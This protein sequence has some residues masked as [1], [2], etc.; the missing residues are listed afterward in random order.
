MTLSLTLK[1]SSCVFLFLLVSFPPP[2]II[3]FSCRF[4]FQ[5]CFVPVDIFFFLLNSLY[6]AVFAHLIP[7]LCHLFV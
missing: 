4:P 3:Y 1:V 7:F 6:P 2:I 5:F